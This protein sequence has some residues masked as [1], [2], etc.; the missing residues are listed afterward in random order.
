MLGWVEVLGLVRVSETKL[1]QTKES[2]S[3]K[4]EM[5]QFGLRVGELP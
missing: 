2:K 3:Q 4:T 5:V 1:E